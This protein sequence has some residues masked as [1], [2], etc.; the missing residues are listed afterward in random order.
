M[1]HSEEHIAEAKSR[2]SLV[3]IDPNSSATRKT[4]GQRT[5]NNVVSACMASE[6]VDRASPE[7]ETISYYS[8]KTTLHF[9]VQREEHFK[10]RAI[11]EGFPDLA[12]RNR[13]VEWR[14]CISQVVQERHGARS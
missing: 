9:V 10:L 4:A 1:K 11:F 2:N 12:R 5:E 3:R 8:T 6:G 7:I 13:V 14:I